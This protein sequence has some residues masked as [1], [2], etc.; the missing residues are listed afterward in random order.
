MRKFLL[1]F[2]IYKYKDGGLKKLRYLQAAAGILG[3]VI[4]LFLIPFGYMCDMQSKVLRSILLGRLSK[5]DHIEYSEQDAACNT[6]DNDID[7][8]IVK[9]KIIRVTVVIVV[10]M[11]ILFLV[12]Q[13]NRMP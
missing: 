2:G 12:D 3:S 5:Y 11:L 7:T 9:I 6:P 10:G 4:S 1:K 8:H 13:V